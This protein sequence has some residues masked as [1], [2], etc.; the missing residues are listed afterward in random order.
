VIRVVRLAG[1]ARQETGHDFFKGRLAVPKPEIIGS[2]QS[3]YTRVVRMACE[4]R[5]RR[6]NHW[7]RHCR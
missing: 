4:A 6:C 5:D 2:A 3:S 1:L 7:S